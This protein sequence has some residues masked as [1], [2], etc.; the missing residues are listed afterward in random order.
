MLT[1]GLPHK[2]LQCVKLQTTDPL[3][4]VL[5]QTHESQGPVFVDLE[6]AA[7][8]DLDS[9]PMLRS[10]NAQRSDWQRRLRQPVALGLPE[11]GLPLMARE[12]PDFLDWRSDT[13][14]IPELTEHELA[15]M[16]CST[17]AAPMRTGSVAQRPSVQTRTLR[18]ARE[19]ALCVL[20]S[21]EEERSLLA[22]QDARAELALGD[23]EVDRDL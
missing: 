3:N 8:R 16:P 17:Q 23:E 9:H 13:I 15:S 12:A 2:R 6:Q 10:L 18:E 5:S 19:H 11:C 22:L 21:A 4:E 14:V 1:E 7:T 20:R